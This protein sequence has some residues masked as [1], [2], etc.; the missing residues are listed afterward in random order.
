MSE[1]RGKR[2]RVRAVILCP[3][4]F[5]GIA[6]PDSLQEIQIFTQKHN[7]CIGIINFWNILIHIKPPFINVFNFA[8]IMHN[9]INQSKKLLP[10]WNFQSLHFRWVLLCCYSVRYN[11]TTEVTRSI[12]RKV[13]VI[14]LK[15][16]V[17]K[18]QLNKNMQILPLCKNVNKTIQIIT[19][20]L[21]SRD[22]IHDKSIIVR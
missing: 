12:L 19:Q 22:K 11:A 2:W 20:S 17:K 21:Q 6:A 5:S 8:T 1:N 13:N 7:A 15:K 3:H 18:S 10:I 9:P 14:F 16:R 4:Q